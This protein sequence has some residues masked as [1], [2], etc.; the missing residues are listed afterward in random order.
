[1][2]RLERKRCLWL[3]F[4]AH[5][6]ASL[7]W[8]MET[9]LMGLICQ[10]KLIVSRHEVMR[11]ITTIHQRWG[12]LQRQWHNCE[13]DKRHKS[14]IKWV[15]PELRR[16]TRRGGGGWN[17]WQLRAATFTLRRLGAKRGLSLAKHLVYIEIWYDPWSQ[18]FS[19]N[20]IYIYLYLSRLA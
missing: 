18:L 14:E 5:C 11:T 10:E 4:S 12:Q 9:T 7:V 16:C 15:G 20:Q 17:V 3:K 13:L 6:L 19:A 1:M 8:W 2:P